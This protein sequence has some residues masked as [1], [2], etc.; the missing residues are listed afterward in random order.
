MKKTDYRKLNAVI[1][2]VEEALDRKLKVEKGM[3]NIC[4]RYTSANLRNIVKCLLEG[5]YPIVEGVELHHDLA[6]ALGVAL[7]AYGDESARNEDVKDL[8]KKWNSGRRKK[9]LKA[10]K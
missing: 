3:V 4:L 9:A 2:N 1:K 6:K 7:E 5:E 10:L 8:I